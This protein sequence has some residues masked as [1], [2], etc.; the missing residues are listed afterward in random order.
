[1][2]NILKTPPA[3]SV[4]LDANN[5][6]IS[7]QST[8]GA[9]HYFRA[10]IYINDV[11]FDEQGWSRQDNFTANKDLKKMYAAYFASTFTPT[12]VGGLTEQTQ[13]IK[14]VNITINE[15]VL[16]TGA[17]VN[18]V[19]LPVFHIMH[20]Q[21]PESFSDETKVQFL[22]IQPA[23][24]QIPQTGQLSIPFF[25]N[26]NNESIVVK[27]YHLTTIVDTITLTEVTGKKA[28]LYKA[29][30]TALTFPKAFE[31][32][33]LDIS[34]GAA[35]VSKT[36]KFFILPN[37]SIK[38][39]AFKNNFGFYL[40]SY[41]DGELEIVNDFKAETYT[42]IDGT[43]KTFEINENAT[44]SINTGALLDNEKAIIRQVCN[45]LDTRFLYETKWL[46]ILTKTKKFK[47]FKDNNH[48][49]NEDL[50]FSFSKNRDIANK[51]F[52]SIP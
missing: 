3:N 25:V 38:S 26:A 31:Y 49:F 36:F 16:A 13:F 51:T 32:L 52:V 15:H 18:T 33:T 2:I 20:N 1:M 7:I 47:E 19:N 8:L 46:E 50:V 6:V 9:G 45:S 24:L 23:V 30:L 41:F 39:I 5:S 21:N 12:I 48:S 10:L 37:Y 22:D 27:L 34:C 29:D 14:K 44:Y 17:I 43:D 4:L 35:K 28:Y 40:R 11:L 42:Q